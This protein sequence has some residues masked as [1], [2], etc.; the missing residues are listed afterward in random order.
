MDY[1]PEPTADGELS[2]A[3]DPEPEPVP[4]KEPEPVATSATETEPQSDSDHVHEPATSV[5]DRTL[6]E[7]D[8]EE[9]LID[10]KMEV[11]LP[12]NLHHRHWSC[13]E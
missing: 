11:T 13:P 5:T 12:T 8:T 2:L 4:T 9:C 6:V 7:L 10:W 1:K 3:R